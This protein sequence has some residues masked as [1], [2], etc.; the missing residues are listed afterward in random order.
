[1]AGTN[2]TMTGTPR[3]A[4]PH[5]PV[6]Y[7]C[8]AGVALAAG[9]VCYVDS[10][11]KA[12]LADKAVCTITTTSKYEGIS[13]PAVSAGCPVTLFG[14]GAKIHIS[15]T[16]QVIGSFW[17]VSDTAGLLKDTKQAATDTY[18]PVGK[19]I[20]ANILEIVRRGV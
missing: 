7:T 3:L 11:G 2:M 17:W 4:D 16:V 10:A 8:I 5:A 19:M 12:Q 18:L 6:R 14:L 1:M 13:I 15:D 20:T 9:S